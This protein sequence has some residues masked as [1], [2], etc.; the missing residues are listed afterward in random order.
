M[1]VFK[2]RVLLDSEVTIFRDIE[3]KASQTFEELHNAILDAFEFEG[4]EMASFY[5]S[6]DNWDKGKE[7][8]LED[9]SDSDESTVKTMADTLISDL[10]KSMNQKYIYV[11][12][13]LKMWCFYVEVLGIAEEDKKEKYPFVSMTYGDAPS[14]DSKEADYSEDFDGLSGFEDEEADI[15]KNYDID[16]E[17]DDMFNDLDEDYDDRTYDDY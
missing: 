3:I 7:I 16:D 5:Q 8:P 6:N 15:K 12:D 4:T 14:E 17:I 1:K 2:F 10:T 9:L 13:F 11:Y